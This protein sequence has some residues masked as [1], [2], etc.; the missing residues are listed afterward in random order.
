VSANFSTECRSRNPSPMRRIARA[1]VVAVPRHAGLPGAVS[2][3]HLRHGRKP[4]RSAAAALGTKK[5]FAWRA[6]TLGHI[7]RQ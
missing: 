6:C 4:N 3:R 2:G 1:T 5:I 7:G